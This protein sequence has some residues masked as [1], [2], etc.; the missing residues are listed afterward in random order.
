MFRWTLEEMKRVWSWEGRGQKKV[1]V[2]IRIDH[3]I[4][5]GVSINN[6]LE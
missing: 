4:V 1:F 5:Q 2:N 3:F 6:C